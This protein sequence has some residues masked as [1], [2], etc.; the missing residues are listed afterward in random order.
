MSD[1]KKIGED[2]V[3][4]FAKEVDTW[5]LFPS[6]IPSEEYIRKL[7]TDYYQLREYRARIVLNLVEKNEQAEMFSLGRESMLKEILEAIGQGEHVERIMHIPLEEII[8][9]Q[10]ENESKN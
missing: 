7:L 6:R 1:Y 4:R 8:H 3:A 10:V 2:R 9:R 5:E